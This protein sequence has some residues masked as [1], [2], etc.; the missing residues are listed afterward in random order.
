[1]LIMIQAL[2]YLLTRSFYALH[3]T[4]TPVR[5]SIGAIIFNICLSF[6]LVLGLGWPVWSLSLSFSLTSI[7]QTLI[8]VVLLDRKTGGLPLNK[9]IMPFFKIF[10]ASSLAG[11]TMF[12]LLKILDRS[13]W[14]KNLSFLGR[15]GLVLPTRFDHFV[16][17]TRYT[18]N[19]I[20]LTFF[21]ALVGGAI[22]LLTAWLLKVEALAVFFKL[23]KRLKKF[24]PPLPRPRSPEKKEALT[25]EV[26]EV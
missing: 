12:F 24:K 5:I 2:I 7:F 18:V 20:C 11:S 9:L 25:V 10:L 15:F 26:K 22:Y 13:A 23:F 16:L 1:M 6:G 19:L 14:D 8:L 17:D 21:V 4:K 3:D